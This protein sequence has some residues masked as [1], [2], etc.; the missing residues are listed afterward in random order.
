MS[1]TVQVNHWDVGV[2]VSILANPA[3]AQLGAVSTTSLPQHSCLWCPSQ[4]WHDNQNPLA[5][6]THVKF[7]FDDSVAGPKHATACGV[8]AQDGVSASTSTG[9]TLACALAKQLQDLWGS[10]DAARGAKSRYS[11]A[12][13]NTTNMSLHHLALQQ[14]LHSY[15]VVLFF[16]SPAERRCAVATL[17]AVALEAKAGSKAFSYTSDVA[18]TFTGDAKKDDVAAAAVAVLAYVWWPQCCLPQC[19]HSAFLAPP[20][21]VHHGWQRSTQ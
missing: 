21:Q 10:R 11:I 19:C 16:A 9:A 8:Q 2:F 4:G 1:P 3:Q 18:P 13:P 15:K 17:L 12:A 14:N 6:G 7:R 20:L 5:W